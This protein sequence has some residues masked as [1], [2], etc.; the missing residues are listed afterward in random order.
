MQSMCPKL[1]ID[2]DSPLLAQFRLTFTSLFLPAAKFAAAIKD[3]C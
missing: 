2:E 3:D 1:R